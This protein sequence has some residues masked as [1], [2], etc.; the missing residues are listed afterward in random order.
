M[1]D[2]SNHDWYLKEQDYLGQGILPGD[3][4]F[5]PGRFLGIVPNLDEELLGRL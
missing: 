5:D 1:R 4:L 2:G 3:A